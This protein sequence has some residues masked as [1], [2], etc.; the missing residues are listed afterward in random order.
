[1]EYKVVMEN[2]RGVKYVLKEDV[3]K[4]SNLPEEKIDELEVYNI[5]YTNDNYDIIGIKCFL[6]SDVEKLEKELLYSKK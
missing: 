5:Y 1:M 4:L 2:K 6:L 3:L